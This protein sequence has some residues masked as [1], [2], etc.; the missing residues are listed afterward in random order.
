MD[1]Q[2]TPQIGQ[3][4]KIVRGR[5]EGKHAV[6]IQVINNRYVLIADGDKRKFDLPKKKN[7]LHIKLLDDVSSEVVNSML[8][9]GRVSNG[10]LRY[11]VGK[12]GKD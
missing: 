8:E 4:V 10:K 2:K 6:V 9:S 11:A 3:I 7:L 12:Y 5:D 1:E